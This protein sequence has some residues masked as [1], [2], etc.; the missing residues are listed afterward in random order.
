MR[1]A[2]RGT[3]G[4]VDGSA[5]GVGHDGNARGFHVL[6][7]GGSCVAKSFAVVF[8][9]DFLALPVHAG[10]FAVVNLHAVHADVAPAGARVAGVHAGQR[11]E[12]AAIVRPAL[13]NGKDVEVEVVAQDDLLTRCVFGSNGL[14]EGAGERAELRQHFELVEEALG[15]LDVHQADDA[16]RDFVEALD[17]ERESH[18]ALAAELVDEDSVAGMTLDVFKKQRRA[19][20]SIM[21]AFAW[22]GRAA[23]G[24][25]LADAIGYLGDLKLGG[26][27]FADALELAVLFEGS[28]PVA[29]IVVSQGIAP[30]G[31]CG[32]HP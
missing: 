4:N 6:R 28:D 32:P 9:G 12:A 7:T 16:L 14:G 10:C 21:G 26:N 29:Q 13:E 15:R 22:R 19:T 1:E 23:P 11:D 30:E 20:G 18:A 24:T 2:A 17:T 3:V 8:R 31:V 5:G 27:L 25:D